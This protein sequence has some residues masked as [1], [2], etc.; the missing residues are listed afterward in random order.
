MIT[1]IFRP[2]N[3]WL[4]GSRRPQ[5]MPGTVATKV[6]AHID[7]R[8]LGVCRCPHKS[9][10]VHTKKLCADTFVATSSRRCGHDARN[11][12]KTADLR[13]W[14]PRR[15]QN[16]RFARN[17]KSHVHTNFF[18]VDTARPRFPRIYKNFNKKLFKYYKMIVQENFFEIF[19]SDF[20]IF[21][22]FVRT[23]LYHNRA[24]P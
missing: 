2:K 23:D 17:F 8:Q 12:Y 10:F 21:F 13:V 3:A 5:R 20:L 7:P 19:F 1:L 11:A 9:F 16:Q 6:S 24:I 15:L 18:C 4:D 22:A 14:T